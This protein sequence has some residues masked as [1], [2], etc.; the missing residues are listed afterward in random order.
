MSVVGAALMCHAPI[1][2]PA[3]G[4][5]RG[6]AS[7][8][9]TAAMRALA[10]QAMAARPDVLLVVSPHA[11][12]ARGAWLLAA[13]DPTEGDFGPFGHPE[14]GVSLPFDTRSARALL[15]TATQADLPV[16]AA[17]LGPLDHGALVPLW[18][19]AETGWS[20]PTLRLALPAQPTPEGCLRMGRAIAAAAEQDGR[21]WLLVCSGDMS[22]RLQP[23]AP[24]G[25]HPDGRRFD[26]TLVRHFEAG[27]W[28]ALAR[29]DPVL[30]ARAAE[31]VLDSLLVGLGA[32]ETAPRRH[33]L[34]SYEGP[35]G[36]GYPVG[37]IHRPATAAAT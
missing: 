21:D 29:I 7:A 34:L 25:H 36:V 6:A 4:G 35:F 14:V 31:D 30:R 9:T 37:W 8:R 20:G 17:E 2:V 32:T 12:R 10:R 15:A 33:E 11:P 1:V 26:E 24:A 19:L 3:I 18:F 22:H 13:D 16:G 27:D 23:G 5:T 28:E